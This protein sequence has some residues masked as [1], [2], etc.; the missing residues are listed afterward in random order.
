VIIVCGRCGAPWNDVAAATPSRPASARLT[1]VAPNPFNPRTT[2]AYVLAKTAVVE[3]SVFDLRGRLVRRLVAEAR[4]SG[5]HLVEWDG[6]DGHGRAVPS[7]RYVAR[8][9]AGD[10][11][12]TRSLT[13]VR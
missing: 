12:A 8:M 6:T 4:R 7:G 2:I 10:V 11:V 13:L 3:L 9:R 5:E 1:R